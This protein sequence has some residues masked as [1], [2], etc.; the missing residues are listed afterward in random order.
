LKLIIT[1]DNIYSGGDLKLEKLHTVEEV[2]SILNV[3]T[4]TIRIWLR[5]GTLKGVKLGKYWRIKESQL[6][7][8][9]KEQEGA[10]DTQ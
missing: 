7:E 8:F 5:K 4:N 10:T 9:T 1:Y 6:Q 3:Q 2:A